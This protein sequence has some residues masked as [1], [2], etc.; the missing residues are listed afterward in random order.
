ML[1][2][3]FDQYLLIQRFYS[4]IFRP[5]DF[6][7]NLWKIFLQTLTI[8]QLFKNIIGRHL[9]GLVLVTGFVSSLSVDSTQQGASKK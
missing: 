6:I 3:D 4:K 8:P 9:P 1:Y 2:K 5:K 7:Y